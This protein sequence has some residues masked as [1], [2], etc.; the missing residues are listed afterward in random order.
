MR[1][2][3]IGGLAALCCCAVQASERPF[4]LSGTAIQED[5]DERVFEFSSW[6][7]KGR[8]FKSL[9]AELQYS[10]VPDFSVELGWGRRLTRTDG[11]REAETELEAGLRKVLRDPA[12]HG[13]GVAFTLEAEAAREVAGGE[14]EGWRYATTTA[15][16]PLSWQWGPV[17][18]HVTVG[19]QHQRRAG[20]RPLA[21]LALL[22]RV[23]SSAELFAEWGAVR[24][25]EGL[26]QAGLRYWL[27]RERV[28]LEVSA[29]RRREGGERV[30][31]LM[32]GL[33]LMDLSF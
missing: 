29:V 32:L 11:E 20:T 3:F 33:S 13:L 1:A 19:L 21:A 22:G 9:N 10:F 17:W 16:M 31:T 8:G 18:T 12:R 14:R 24:E 7:E 27:R 2:L 25:R 30:E 23:S 6:A 5:D 28:A 15:A 4:L 26:A